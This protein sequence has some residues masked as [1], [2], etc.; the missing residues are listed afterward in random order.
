[1]HIREF[2]IPDRNPQDGFMSVRDKVEAE[3]RLPPLTPERRVTPVF[4]REFL[5]KGM[6]FVDYLRT[7]A[8][9]EKP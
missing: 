2:G 6:E 7:Q 1:M 5:A 8:D 9:L 4:A 3:F